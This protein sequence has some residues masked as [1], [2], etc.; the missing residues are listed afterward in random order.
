MIGAIIGAATSI[1]SSV[2]G[3]IRAN[4]AA[5]KAKAEIENAA[6]KS[7]QALSS[8]FSEAQNAQRGAYTNAMASINSE[9]SFLDNW[10]KK[11]QATD[12]TQSAE[13]MAMMNQAKEAAQEQLDRAEGSAA[14]MGGT[15]ASV[16]NARAQAAD[17]MSENLRNLA[18]NASQERQSAE[19]QYMSARQALGAESRNID[20]NSGA[21][22]ANLAANKGT[23]M[24]GHYQSV[25]QQMANIYNQ[26][27]ANATQG[28]NA[29]MSAGMGLVSADAQSVIDTGKGLFSNLFKKK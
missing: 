25:G 13:G 22:L 11:K 4:K 2:A 17:V 3:G 9:R 8:G 7:E 28:A 5:K 23:A 14:V 6:A 26:Q 24:A 21:Q 16:A 27:A 19:Q 12:Y 15:D 1:A 10:N 29:G 18:L 20:M